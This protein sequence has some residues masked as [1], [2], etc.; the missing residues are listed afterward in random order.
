MLHLSVSTPNNQDLSSFVWFVSLENL[1]AKEE[2]DIVRHG[3][4]AGLHFIKP[5]W[6]ASYKEKNPF[7]SSLELLIILLSTYILLYILA[8]LKYIHP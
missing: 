6:V 2:T 1:K 5:H 8:K 3:Q 7:D 4:Q